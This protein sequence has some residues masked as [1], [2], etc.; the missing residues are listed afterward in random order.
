M[1]PLVQ[2][3]NNARALLLEAFQSSPIHRGG[4]RHQ[5]I[6][7]AL[8]LCESLSDS[9][10][11]YE[12][13]IFQPA[14][15]ALKVAVDQ[16]QLAALHGRRVTLPVLPQQDSHL[17]APRPVLY[18]ATPSPPPQPVSTISTKELPPPPPVTAIPDQTPP[19]TTY[20]EPL[21]PPEP[22]LPP[23]PAPAIPDQTPPTQ[24]PKRGRDDE[25]AVIEDQVAVIE[26]RQ[27][28]LKEEAKATKKAEAKSLRARLAELTADGGDE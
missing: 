19:P 27:L 14:I 13:A 16:A 17:A 25:V 23:P 1:D 8:R 7:H 26:A 21:P 24:P 2:K 11:V 6:S 28:A 9:L 12:S 18:H 20:E 5:L 4:Q 22:K 3:Y 15:V 10:G